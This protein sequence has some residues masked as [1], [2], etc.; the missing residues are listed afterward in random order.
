VGVGFGVGVGE[1][2]GVGVGVG[3]GGGVGVT[4]TVAAPLPTG[5]WAWEVL[6]AFISEI[7]PMVNKKPALKPNAMPMSS[8]RHPVGGWR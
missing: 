1:G 2:G 3:E 4:L 5:D 8:A 6:F 7:M